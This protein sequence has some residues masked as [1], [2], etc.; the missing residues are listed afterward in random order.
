MV[1]SGRKPKTPTQEI[2][3]LTSE[4]KSCN[5][6][7]IKEIH[8]SFSQR[9]RHSS[10]DIF[11]FQ[12]LKGAVIYNATVDTEGMKLIFWEVPQPKNTCS[13]QIPTCAVYST[14]FCFISWRWLA[15]TLHKTQKKKKIKI[16]IWVLFFYLGNF[17]RLLY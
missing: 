2:S 10:E 7:L 15:M 16:L 17:K 8:K 9:W 12:D 3:M 14:G 6:C 13:K 5:L 11:I 4:Y 1:F